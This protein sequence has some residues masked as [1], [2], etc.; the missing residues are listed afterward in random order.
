MLTG[1]P[2]PLTE[3]EFFD[4]VKTWF[5]R[6]YDIKYMM[7]QIKPSIKGGLLEISQDLGVSTGVRLLVLFFAEPNIP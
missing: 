5:P 7:R 1:A 6:L 4:M 2:L 3:E